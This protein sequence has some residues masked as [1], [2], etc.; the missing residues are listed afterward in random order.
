[1]GQPLV[2]DFSSMDAYLNSSLQ[3]KEG[4]P[5]VAH[6]KDAPKSILRQVSNFEDLKIWRHGA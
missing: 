6:P 3:S 5:S 4:I 1:M 2:S